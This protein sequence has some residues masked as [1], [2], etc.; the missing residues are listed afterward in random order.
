MGDEVGLPV[1][2]AYLQHVMEPLDLAGFLFCQEECKTM[3][4][5]HTGH[6][7]TYRCYSWALYQSV[8]FIRM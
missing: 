2:R 6:T 7:L 4:G 5:S 1:A 8:I 3:W